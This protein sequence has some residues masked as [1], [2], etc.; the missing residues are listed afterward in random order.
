MYKPF[1]MGAKTGARLERE[2]IMNLVWGWCKANKNVSQSQWE[3]LSELI[4]ENA[5]DTRKFKK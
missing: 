2:R 4:V 1:V 3:E 5:P